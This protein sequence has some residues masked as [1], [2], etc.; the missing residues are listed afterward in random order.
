MN[1]LLKKIYN[2]KIR[3]FLYPFLFIVICYL[4]AIIFADKIQTYLLF[5]SLKTE[6]QAENTKILAPFLFEEINIPL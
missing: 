6:K 5:P 2:K 4:L 3:Y 1:K